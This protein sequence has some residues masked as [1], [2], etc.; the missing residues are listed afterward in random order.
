MRY[1]LTPRWDTQLAVSQ[2]RDELSTFEGGTFADRESRFD[3]RRDMADWQNTIRLQGDWLLLAGMDAY[4]DRVSS[5]EPFAEDSRYNIGIHSVISGY[6]GTHDLT[7]SLRY[8]DNEQFG[9]KTT[10][11]IGWGIPVSGTTHVRASA[12]TAF[13]APSFNELYFPD[14]AFFRGNPDLSPEESRTVELGARYDS[15]PRFVDVAAF[16]TE[17]DDLITSVPDE[18]WTF[19][20]TNI[21]RARIQGLE[22]EAGYQTAAWSTRAS[23]TLLNTEDRATGNELR[24]RAPASGRVDVDRRIGNLSLGGSLIGQ[25]RSFEDAA[26]TDRLSGFA[27]VDL[28]ATYMIDRE[29]SAAASVQNLFD[30]DYAV[31]RQFGT[32]YNQPGRGLFVTLRYEQR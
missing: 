2:S 7:A 4:E 29:W 15:G 3:S 31:S 23:L 11:Q 32:D 24:R 13:K 14:S 9:D 1:A 16:H 20:P 10:G 8:D 19:V 22:L 30:R 28:R 6:V 12:G 5:S 27:T 26:N 21:D 25:G 17:I 18:Q